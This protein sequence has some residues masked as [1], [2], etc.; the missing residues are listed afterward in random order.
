MTPH[1]V[2][3][4]PA[5]LLDIHKELHRSYHKHGN[6]QGQD[7]DGIFTII[8]EELREAH[9][10]MLRQDRDGPHG[11]YVE[12]CQVAACC[13]KAIVELGDAENVDIPVDN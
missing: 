11:Y 5:I 3:Q 10:A 1:K 2:S 4:M 7:V 8:H 13:I 6:W 9:D 12:L